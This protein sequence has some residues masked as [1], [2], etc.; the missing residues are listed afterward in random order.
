M[1]AQLALATA[2]DSSRFLPEPHA[3]WTVPVGIVLVLLAGFWLVRKL[4][5]LALV[6]V[7]IAA[8]LFAYQGGAFDHYVDKGKQVI[9]KQQQG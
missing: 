3:G 9:Q 1:S 4:I 7:V 2:A 6:A 5:K 8:V